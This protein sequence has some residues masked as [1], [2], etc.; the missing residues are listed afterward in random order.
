MIVFV[1]IF[2]HIKRK[3]AVLI[4][5]NKFNSL[6]ITILSTLANVKIDINKAQ[7]QQAYFK[8]YGAAVFLLLKYL[9]PLSQRKSTQ[10]EHTLPY[11]YS[12]CIVLLCK[13]GVK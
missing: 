2:F 7:K 8:Q 1:F 9:Q 10:R 12:I 13:F 6:S 3:H 11:S 5:C 4:S